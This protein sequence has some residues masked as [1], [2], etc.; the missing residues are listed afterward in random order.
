MNDPVRIKLITFLYRTPPVAASAFSNYMCI[1]DL[2]KLDFL[3]S[4]FIFFF[5]HKFL[6]FLF[7][8]SLIIMLLSSVRWKFS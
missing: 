4:F 3:S 6:K 5:V 8:L 2:I 7:D 1:V